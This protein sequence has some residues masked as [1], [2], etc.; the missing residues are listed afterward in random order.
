MELLEVAKFYPS[1]LINAVYQEVP[2]NEW[3]K[4]FKYISTRESLSQARIA[5]HGATAEVVPDLIFTHN[6]PRPKIT[7]DLCVTDSAGKRGGLNPLDAQFIWKM[8]SAAK[9]CTG[10]F[11]GACLAMLWGMPFSA[12]PSNTHKTEG[13]LI[14]AGCSHLFKPSKQEALESI[15]EFDASGYI[16]GARKAIGDM[17]DRVVECV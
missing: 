6:I 10:R 7:E 3:I 12:Y 4:G 1:A 13:M 5:E 2:S 11:H 14:D 8:G 16:R 9:V 15:G 17:F